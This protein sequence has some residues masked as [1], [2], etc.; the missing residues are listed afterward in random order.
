M[1]TAL[2]KKKKKKKSTEEMTFGVIISHVVNYAAY[3]RIRVTVGCNIASFFSSLH[4]Y[5]IMLN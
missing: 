3:A 2:S 4:G 5:F 1:G